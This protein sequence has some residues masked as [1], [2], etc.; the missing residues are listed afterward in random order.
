MSLQYSKRGKLQKSNDRSGICS[1]PTVARW[2][3][4]LRIRS[5]GYWKKENALH[6]SLQKITGELYKNK[7]NIQA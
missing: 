1:M 5:E 4:D 6:S 3:T 2:M 7:K